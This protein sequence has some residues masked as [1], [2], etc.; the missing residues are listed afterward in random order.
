MFANVYF[1]TGDDTNSA[2]NWLDGAQS[3]IIYEWTDYRSLPLS[4]RQFVYATTSSWT[5]LNKQTN[6]WGNM[7]Y[8][9]QRIWDGFSPGGFDYISKCQLIFF[10]LSRSRSFTFNSVV[11]TKRNNS[12]KFLLLLKKKTRKITNKRLSSFSSSFL[13]P[14]TQWIPQL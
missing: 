9:A 8:L 14:R 10:S 11:R 2:T 7:R 1:M 5:F 4:D 3:Y 13:S 12:C 6:S